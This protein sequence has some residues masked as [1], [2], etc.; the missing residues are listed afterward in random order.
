M[1][2]VAA[3]RWFDPSA[4]RRTSTRG[5]DPTGTS[6]RSAL[7]S[8]TANEASRTDNLRETFGGVA[9]SVLINNVDDHWRNH[10]FARTGAGWRLSPLF[11]VHRSMQRGAIDSRATSDK[12]DPGD[13]Q[14]VHLLEIAGAFRLREPE[15]KGVLLR[16]VAE[17]V[18][19]WRTV[20]ERVGLHAEQ[21]E[22]LRGAFETP[23]LEWAL[24]LE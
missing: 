7:T 16:R 3:A 20:A 8:A 2:G 11:D 15:A 19:G 4:G 18:A 24:S 10:A 12:D 14:L 13:R 1:G 22:L 21:Q 9:L 23:Q 5:G 17:A 6:P